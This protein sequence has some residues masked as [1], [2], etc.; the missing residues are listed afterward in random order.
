M[1]M[2]KKGIFFLM[3]T[4]I[5]ISIFLLSLAFVSESGSRKSV[6]K[7]VGTLSDFVSSTEEDLPRQLF[8]FGY[9]TVFLM[10]NQIVQ[11]GNYL[12]TGKFS[13]LMDEAFLQG[14]L[15]GAPQEML[16]GSTYDDIADLLEE[17]AGK[18]SADVVLSNPNLTVT[19]V[20]PWNLKLTF[21]SD[22][23][24]KD[25]N[26]LATW[27]KT[28][29]SE[30]Y[31][32]LSNF[33]DPVYLKGAGVSKHIRQNPSEVFGSVELVKNQLDNGYYVSHSG[34]PSFIDRL[35]GNI[36]GAYVS[37][38]SPEYGIESFVDLQ[39]DLGGGPQPQRS[40]ID[41][42][43]F[44]GGTHNYCAIGGG[45]PSWFRLDYPDHTGFYGVSC[46]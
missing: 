23:F 8:I 22:F 25:R 21:V 43:F 28:F 41:Y 36:G 9:R 14:S 37:P 20:D 15:D 4:L 11:T 34:A 44:N 33:T 40:V 32:S 5:V 29:V 31:I 39:N 45:L 19:Q 3:V 38:Q 16:A 30:V 12:G 6:Q 2:N 35:E 7:R 42:L 26:D 10:E 24:V 1:G 13:S 46:S 17:R 18:I 27:N